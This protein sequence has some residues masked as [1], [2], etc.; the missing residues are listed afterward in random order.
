MNLKSNQSTQTPALT[1]VVVSFNTR[2]ILYASLSRLAEQV[3]ALPAHVIVVDNASADGSAAMVAEHFPQFQLICSG[4]NLGFAAAN[5]LGF[6]LSRG[7]YLVL[8]NPDAI[9]GEGALRKAFERM[10]L[11]PM[12]GM[13]GG[14]L[15]NESGETQPSGR[16]FP[17]LFNE[18]LT[19]SGLAAR[20]PHSRLFGRFDRTWADPGD[21]ARVDWV[22]GAFTIIRREALLAVGTFDERFFLYYEEVD[23]CRRMA[24]AGYEVWYWPEIVVTHIGGA[25]AKTLASEDFSESGAQLTLW[26]MRSELLYFRK[27]HGAR[28]AWLLAQ[29]DIGWNCLRL[30]RPDKRGDAKR[31]DQLSRAMQLMRQAWRDTLGGTVSPPRPW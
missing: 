7:E 22:S 29:L 25:S 10:E 19:L 5:N 3:A 21:A 14:R 11:A 9:L 12:V 8:L 23:L 30:S 18:F 27:Y 24:E 17:S 15:Q 6:L 1:V 28:G 26:R 13:A 31:R 4:A 16:K 20:A 2:E